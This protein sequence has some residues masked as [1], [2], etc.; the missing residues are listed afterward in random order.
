[1]L[2]QGIEWQGFA[3]PFKKPFA[4]SKSVI[5]ERYGLLVWVETNDGITGLG[6]AP[7]ALESGPGSLR[8]TAEQMGD[9]APTLLGK[10]LAPTALPATLSPSLRFALETAALDCIAQSEGR[11]LTELLGGRVRPVEV[12]AV[13][14]QGDDAE[15]EASARQAVAD[16]YRTLKL[17]VGGRE[18]AEDQLVVGRVRGA[19]G[20]GVAIR[21]DANRAWPE[22]RAL[23]ALEGLAQ[24]SPEY[25]EEPVAPATTSS[26]AGLRRASPIPIAADE[27][28]EGRE[29]VAALLE[30]G[31]VDVLVIKPARVG[32][33][34][35]ARSIVEDARSEGVDVVL[36][37]MLESGV[38]LAAA[39]HLAAA[40]NLRR[41]CGLATGPL[42]AHDLL[43]QPMTPVNGSLIV[44][45]APGL[46]ISLDPTAIRRFSVGPRGRAR[47]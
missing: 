35:E 12:N 38:G 42:L 7:A 29:S 1:M 13:I 27:S 41:A 10:T 33:V 31:A 44:P 39:A 47:L 43:E 18:L 34:L 25:V 36:T 28:V 26:L 30:A 2:I 3:V 40:L 8:S 9:L 15:T 21:L 46:G 45:H 4:T 23:S 19:V 32:G 14:G 20:D 11:P 17:K 5:A 37:S 6:E 16:G 22:A 24:Y